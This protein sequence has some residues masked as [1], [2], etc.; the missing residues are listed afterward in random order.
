MRILQSL[1]I[2]KIRPTRPRPLIFE[3][4]HSQTI[5]NLKNGG[6]LPEKKPRPVE[7]GG[8]KYE[9]WIF[10]SSA[11][12]VLDSNMLRFFFFAE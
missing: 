2:P 11:S 12:F 4:I 6:M 9:Q 1:S 3:Y 7:M 8:K 5:F 10:Y